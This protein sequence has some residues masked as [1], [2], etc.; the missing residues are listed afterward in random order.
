MLH[1]AP[2]GFVEH[3]HDVSRL[4]V[5][6]QDQWRPRDH[7]LHGVAPRALEVTVKQRFEEKK[8][9][10]IDKLAL[11]HVFFGLWSL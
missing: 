3:H 6:H 2:L 9:S 10:I 11:Q 7:L 4:A 1:C 5:V 8:L